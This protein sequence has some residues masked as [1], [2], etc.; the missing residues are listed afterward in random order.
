MPIAAALVALAL[1]APAQAAIGIYAVVV[2]CTADALICFEHRP[3]R[4]DT[5]AECKAHVAKAREATPRF[6]VMGKCVSRTPP[7]GREYRA[8]AS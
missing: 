2:E 5:W 4:F 1:A 3:V 6:L 7:H 8:P